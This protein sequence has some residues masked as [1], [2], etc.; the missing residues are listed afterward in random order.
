MARLFHRA[1]VVNPPLLVPP[2]AIDQPPLAFYGALMSATALVRSGAQV[3]VADAFPEVSPTELSGGWIRL[4][5]PVDRFLE[6]LEDR[7]VDLVVI[8]HPP[9]AR[10]E[11]NLNDVLHPLVAALAAPGRTIVL[12]D[13]H[14][15]DTHYVAEDSGW[16]FS[17]FPQVNGLAIREPEHPLRALWRGNEHPRLILREG[18]PVPGALGAQ[19]KTWDGLGAMAEVER[20]VDWLKSPV[21]GDLLPGRQEGLAIFPYMASRGC[22]FA[23][24][25]CTSER[26]RPFVGLPLSQVRKD[27]TT[28]RGRGVEEIWLLDPIANARKKR[29]GDILA[30]FEELQLGLVLCNGLRMDRLDKDWLGALAR[31]SRRVPMSVES[32]DESVLASLDKKLS[33]KAVRRAFSMIAEAGLMTEAH[34]LMGAPGEDAEAAGRTLAL[35]MEARSRWGAEPLVQFHVP[36]EHFRVPTPEGLGLPGDFYDAFHKRPVQTPGALAPERLLELMDSFRRKLRAETQSKLIMNLTYRCVNQCLFCSV[37]DR[38]AVD[39]LLTDQTRAMEEAAAQGIRLLDLDG[40]EPTLY[41]H[42][43]QVIDRARDLGFERITVTT[44]GRRLD[45]GEILSALARRKVDLLISL[46]GPSAEVHDPLTGVPGSFVETMGGLKRALFRLS[47]VGVNTTVVAANL[48]HLSD[49]QERL[50]ELGVRRWNLQMVTPFGR[51]ENQPHL[52]P[53]WEAA[54]PLLRSLVNQS[55]A[56]MDVSLVGLPPCGLGDLEEYALDDHHKSVRRMLF[57]TGEAVNLG[58]YLDERRRHQP[59]CR[60][61]ARRLLCGGMWRF[62]APATHDEDRDATIGAVTGGSVDEGVEGPACRNAASDVEAPGPHLLEPGLPAAGPVR[63]LDLITGYACNLVCDYCS[64]TG[65]MRKTHMD[66]RQA[67]RFLHQGR[68]RGI[69]YVSF[70]GG[71]PSILPGILRLTRAASRLGYGTIRYQTNGLR[72]AYPEFTERALAAGLNRVHISFMTANADLYDRI[73][74]LSGSRDLVLSG[75][76]QLIS[77]GVALAGDLIVKSDTFAHLHDTVKLLYEHG[78]RELYLWLVSLTDRNRDNLDSLRP[79][80]EMRPF[81]ESA[82][83]YGR[84]QGIRVMSRHIPACMLR[85]YE[86]QVVRLG[87][88]DVWV[89]TPR[90]SFWLVESV[91]SANR[92]APRCAGCLSQGVCFGLR[93]DYLHRYGDS[94]V[95]PYLPSGAEEPEP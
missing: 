60:T 39:G 40:G 47:G 87:E 26:G 44:N 69:D 13:G 36:R 90:S 3:S 5:P 73:T 33:L 45:D 28:L 80:S 48:D 17:R 46:H 61:C 89:V 81:I 50:V 79:V 43:L 25:F 71:E 11:R 54:V 7:E 9:M 6:S 42:L 35:A 10:L 23:C 72:F 91:I 86:D 92:F 76:A 55:T 62:Q 67:L 63:M 82:L 68:D 75:I 95:R 30:I 37:G 14:L 29:F 83:D 65:D 74:G 2:R 85:G 84:E 22:P 20:Y 1:L 59:M 93:E 56:T 53:P 78:V 15:T 57:A 27:L 64:V 51:A 12:A 16:L 8:H 41:P 70:G 58:A 77:R 31:R 66:P 4:G 21:L 34:Y 32:G 49:L 24:S 18:P 88:E 94:E 19:A 52:A 38:P